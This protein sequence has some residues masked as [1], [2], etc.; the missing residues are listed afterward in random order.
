K[1]GS[2]VIVGRIVLSGKPAIIPKK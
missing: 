2:V 1:K